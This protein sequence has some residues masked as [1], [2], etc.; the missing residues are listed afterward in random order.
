MVKTY[1]EGMTEVPELADAFYLSMLNRISDFASTIGAQL[2]FVTEDHDGNSAELRL[3]WE[4]AADA[5]GF[6]LSDLLVEQG[7]YDAVTLL[8]D[9]DTT[10]D[11]P[12]IR[13]FDGVVRQGFG[14]RTIL[15]GENATAYSQFKP[16][17]DATEYQIYFRLGL[18]TEGNG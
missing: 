14:E 16:A 15:L 13:S 11:D 4:I 18:R 8:L 12:L 9:G 3:D 6:D 17:K 2:D 10:S 7:F 5:T 1:A